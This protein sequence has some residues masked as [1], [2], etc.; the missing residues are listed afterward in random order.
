MSDALGKIALYAAGSFIVGLVA[1]KAGKKRAQRIATGDLSA[2]EG[3]PKVQLPGIGADADEDPILDER[4]RQIACEEGWESAANFYW[5]AAKGQKNVRRKYLNAKGSAMMKA[6]S[7][8]QS[9][10]LRVIF[11]PLLLICAFSFGYACLEDYFSRDV[12][13]QPAPTAPAQSH[14]DAL[15]RSPEFLRAHGLRPEPPRK[16]SLPTLSDP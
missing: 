5:K 1:T 11:V 3:L 2:L 6:H 8:E 13:S 16:R 10:A 7:K 9:R 14:L 12:R 15:G 4:A